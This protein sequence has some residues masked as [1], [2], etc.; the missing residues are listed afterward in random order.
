[1]NIIVGCRCLN[2]EASEDLTSPVCFVSFPVG[3]ADRQLRRR[4]RS[5]RLFG[6]MSWKLTAAGDHDAGIRGS[7]QRGPRHGCHH[8]QGY[9]T[10]VEV[11]KTSSQPHTRHDTEH[12]DKRRAHQLVSS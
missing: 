3:P 1:M 8:L 7:S 2:A 11:V 5:H 12:V 9:L 4:G 6:Q 10:L